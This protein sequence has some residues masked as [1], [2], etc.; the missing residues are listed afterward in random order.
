V[1]AKSAHMSPPPL[2]AG[3]PAPLVAGCIGKGP[4]GRGTLCRGGSTLGSSE[5][6]EPEVAA[7]DA[8]TS[9]AGS[10]LVFAPSAVGGSCRGDGARPASVV[11]LALTASGSRASACR[12]PVTRRWAAGDW[13]RSGGWSLRAEASK[14]M[15]VRADGEEASPK[16]ADEILSSKRASPLAES[17]ESSCSFAA[18]IGSGS[19]AG[20]LSLIWSPLSPSHSLSLSPGLLL[21]CQTKW[22]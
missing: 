9:S 19:G 4:G 1:D 3:C 16:C 12:G 2:V 14:A 10:P 11:G 17:C 18:L 22:N 15:C 13:N 5:G 21:S 7:D 8:A 20:P 6:I